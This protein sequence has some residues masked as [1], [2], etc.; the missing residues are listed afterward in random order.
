MFR[1]YTIDARVGL[2]NIGSNDW[3]EVYQ[4][5]LRDLTCPL[6][7]RAGRERFST[8]ILKMGSSKLEILD[9]LLGLAVRLEYGE[10]RG[11]YK[12]FTKEYV[13]SQRAAPPKLVSDN[14]LDS[15]DFSSPD[16]QSGVRALADSLKVGL[17]VY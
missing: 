17:S 9:W 5:Y 12:K 14:P 13:A 1:H 16:F 6:V 7:G 8:D 11:E 10:R 4:K 15:L 2:R 3:E